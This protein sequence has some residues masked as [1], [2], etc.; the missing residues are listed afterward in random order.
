MAV[1]AAKKHLRKELKR[2]LAAMSDQQFQ[3]ESAV[4]VKK[5]NTRLVVLLIYMTDGWLCALQVLAT[6]E[7]GNSK[8]LSVYLSMPMEVNTHQI[9]EVAFLHCE[10]STIL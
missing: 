5:V 2:A 1:I 7:Y 3:E 9:L 4:L 6:E 8:R 10:C